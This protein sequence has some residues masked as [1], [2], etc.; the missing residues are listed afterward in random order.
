MP[1]EV[2]DINELMEKRRKSVAETIQP[3]TIEELK[4][5]GEGLFPI[6][7]HPW[8]QTFF[9]FLEQ[10]ASARFHHGTTHDRVEIIYCQD[11]DKGIWFMPGGGV[12]PLQERGLQIL[13][14][15]VAKR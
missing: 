6:L 12:G 13:K 14:E 15:I 4:E 8:R 1:T 5:I 11:Q 2:P 9:E 7:D 3:I 10:N